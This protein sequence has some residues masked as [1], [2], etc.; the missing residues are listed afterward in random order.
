MT[1]VTFIKVEIYTLM[2]IDTNQTFTSIDGK[3]NSKDIG[4]HDGVIKLVD[5]GITKV[6]YSSLEGER[7]LDSLNPSYAL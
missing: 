4:W 2:F 6:C 7:Y 3:Y 1:E 5:K